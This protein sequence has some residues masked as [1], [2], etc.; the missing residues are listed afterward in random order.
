MSNGYIKNY[1][2][3]FYYYLTE[4]LFLLYNLIIIFKL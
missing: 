3:F 2:Y 1:N 4:K